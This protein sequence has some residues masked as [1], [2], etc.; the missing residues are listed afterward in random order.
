MLGW[1]SSKS[2]LEVGMLHIS[3]DF[4]SSNTVA[5]V[6]GPDEQVSHL[7]I[8]GSPV[9]PSGVFCDKNG[10]LHVGRDAER[11]AEL[12]PAG[13]EPSPKRRVDERLVWLSERDVPVMEMI[14]AVLRRIADELP[15]GEAIRLTMTYPATWGRARRRILVEAATAAGLPEPVLVP[16][17]V[18]A[19][20]YFVD[21]VGSKLDEGRDLLI[22]DFGGGTLDVSIVR[23]T[24]AE[25][26]V[27]CHGGLREFGGIDLDEMLLGVVHNQ[28]SKHRKVDWESLW[29]EPS[30]R[31]QLRREVRDAKEMLSRTSQAPITLP[32]QSLTT[33]V[34]RSE[35]EDAIR[36]RLESAIGEVEKL[37]HQAAL[38]PAQLAGVILVGGSSRIPLVSQL[39]HQRLGIPPTVP[40][41]PEVPVADGAL[42]LLGPPTTPS[43]P[44]QPIHRFGTT[45]ATKALN[46]GVRNR[47]HRRRRI[48]AAAL[49]LVCAAVTSGIYLMTRGHSEE[50]PATQ[51][52]TPP[53]LRELL[54]VAL[55]FRHDKELPT[56]VAGQTLYASGWTD[57]SIRVVAFDLMSGQERWRVDTATWAR[58]LTM[59]V[60]GPT[61]VVTA[62]GEDRRETTA[63]RTDTGQPQWRREG[64]SIDSVGRGLGMLMNPTTGSEPEIVSLKDGKTKWRIRDYPTVIPLHEVNMPGKFEDAST[65]PNGNL[66]LSTRVAVM[67]RS[68]Q[69]RI[70]IHDTATG[71]A[72]TKNVVAPSGGMVQATLIDD[73]LILSVGDTKTATVM[74]LST[75]NLAT[76]WRLTFSLKRGRDEP[77]TV[78][79]LACSSHV[80]CLTYHDTEK[81]YLSNINPQTGKERWRKNDLT[82]QYFTSGPHIIAAND[83]A[84]NTGTLTVLDAQN[85]ETVTT[86]EADSVT[87]SFGLRT[88]ILRPTATGVS[89]DQTRLT[90]LGPDAHSRNDLMM[91]IPAPPDYCHLGV[92]HLACH[93]S[94]EHMRVWELPKW[95]TD[96]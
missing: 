58:G 68:M 92:L 49:A 19:A 73:V 44:R 85:G 25:S 14:G 2:D 4:G 43:S 64:F 22:F 60:D 45:S 59:L 67:D 21:V 9:L 62:A 3:I 95:T 54:N 16:E 48:I 91:K 88:L 24:G 1:S 90:I 72:L 18:A 30:I 38:Q 70:Q 65:L 52:S 77:P 33:H 41:Q 29:S 78:G 87:Y 83:R 80:L 17:P 89:T 47:P 71:K 36:V 27:I 66:G 51:P 63:Y 8:D 79:V 35:F 76:K 39:L 23:R 32:K 12:P 37:L 26:Q 46:P 75:Q 10:S 5:A 6:C 50:P 81:V 94:P 53:E 61:A 56:L 57:E 86:I 40:V 74:G 11:L 93:V 96:Q 7:I 15:A 82:A 69:R 55:P 84:M 13:F 28:A 31:H 34:T 42:R 20:K